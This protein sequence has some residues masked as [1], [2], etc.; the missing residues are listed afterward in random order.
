MMRF[1]HVIGALAVVAMA[2]SLTAAQAQEGRGR[3]PEVP[4]PHNLKV[5]PATMTLQQILPIM[6]NFSAALGTNC[7]YCHQWTG[8]GAAGNDFA[9]DVKPTKETAR[10]MIKMVGD[11]NNT[12]RTNIKGKAADEITRV[13]CI[14]CHRGKAIPEVPAPPARGERGAAP[15]PEPPAGR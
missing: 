10:V 4:P 7:G 12:L 13:Q 2:G 9:A 11:I 3:G 8:A 14:T 5:L 1:R 15:A 6:R